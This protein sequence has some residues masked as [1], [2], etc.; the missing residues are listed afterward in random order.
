MLEIW[1]AKKMTIPE[2]AT[3]Q[4]KAAEVTKLYWKREKNS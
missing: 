1:R 4:E 2:M 3:A